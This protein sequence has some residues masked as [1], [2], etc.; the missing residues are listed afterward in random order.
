MLWFLPTGVD[1]DSP[2]QYAGR[3][4]YIGIEDAKSASHLSVLPLSEE[5]RGLTQY[6]RPRAMQTRDFPKILW[7]V[8][9]AG[10]IITVGAACFFG[11]ND[12]GFHLAQVLVLTFL[13]SLV[14]ARSRTSID[15]TRDW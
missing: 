11:V 10:G 6:R 13:I 5:L 12:F 3:Y 7:A 14:L 9:I 15:L 2:K 8:L 1:R 4:L